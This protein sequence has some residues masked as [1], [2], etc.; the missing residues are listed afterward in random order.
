MECLRMKLSASIG[1]KH[2]SPEFRR[3][4]IK[5][6]EIQKVDRSP[7]IDSPELNI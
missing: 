2:S 6:L 3:I 7:S 1:S 5:I 4:N